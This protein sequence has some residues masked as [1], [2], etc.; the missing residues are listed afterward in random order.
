MSNAKMPQKSS[1][2]RPAWLIPLIITGA[3]IAV[4][5]LIAVISGGSQPTVA[6][7][8]EGAPRAEMDQLS[9]DHGLLRLMEP[10]ESVFT[11]RNVGD[12]VLVILGEPRVELV[13]GCCPPRV[14]TSSTTIDPGGEATIRMT[15]TMHEGMGGQH[16]FRIHVLTNDPTQAE[17]L[18]TARSLWEA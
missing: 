15:Y 12:K 11:I 1:Q 9:I 8:V 6:P 5:A 7:L 3:A 18:L 17:I 2:G 10:V 14:V 13:E 16:E 4:L